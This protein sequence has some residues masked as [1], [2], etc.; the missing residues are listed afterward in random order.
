MGFDAF[1][2]S[3]HAQR[4]GETDD[5]G[6]DRRI[7]VALLGDA[8]DEALVDLDL[9]ERSVLQIA[10]RGIAG[11]EIVQRQ[12]HAQQLQLIE[13]VRSGRFIAEKD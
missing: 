11:A 4:L 3:I 12:A 8:A 7:A 1:G 13:H 9:V 2:G 5:R 10:E 6:D